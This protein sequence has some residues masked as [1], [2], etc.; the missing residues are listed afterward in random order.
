MAALAQ[1]LVAL[2]LQRQ[3][4][5]VDHV[6]EHAGEHAH[7][8]LVFLPVEARLVGEG[9]AHEGGQ[10]DR[11][12]QAGAVGRQRLL[13]AGVGRADVLAPPVVVHLVDPVD[14]DEARL[15][16][17][18]RRDHDHVPQVAGADVA[19]DLAGDQA[20]VAADVVLVRGPFA[21]DDLGLVLEVDLVLFLGVDREDHGP[22]GVVGHRFHEAVG[23]QQRQVEL[24]QAPVLALGPDEIL[25][26]RMGDV[27]GA[28]LRAAT[29][30][31][32]GHG[33][34][35][36]V[37][38]IHERH[39]PG[40]VRAG[41]GDE[42]AARTQGREFIADAAAR[43]EG[44]AGFVDLV[45][46]AVHRVLDGA[47]HGAVDGAG[48]RLV[49]L[50]AGVG[51]D[52][53]GGNGPAAQ[54]PD[55]A[56]VPVGALL[57]G[58]FG[59]GQGP[60]HAL[61]GAVDVGVQR[62]ALLGLEAVLLVPDIQR[63]RLHGYQ[64]SCSFLFRLDR[65]EAHRAHGSVALPVVSGTYGWTCF[66]YAPGRSGRP[67]RRSLLVALVVASGVERQ[68]WRSARRRKARRGGSELCVRSRKTA[69]AV[70]VMGY[71]RSALFP[72]KT[73]LLGPVS[74]LTAISSGK[75]KVASYARRIG[76]STAKRAWTDE[77]R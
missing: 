59:I 33:E 28:H 39:R 29:A 71:P 24:A 51:G 47:G 67:V 44:Q 64:G 4:V 7:H 27:E 12:E 70:A 14:Q 30:T 10:V 6:V 2:L 62:L 72:R 41:T 48:G 17:I 31:G 35:H 53:A 8:F 50:R 69:V 36:L 21:P 66:F 75:A 5:D 54:R 42:R 45:E 57:G 74:H 16:V 37:V 40:R 20:I 65:L 23:D 3:A 55:E 34:A 32:R 46:D 1:D 25:H 60:G 61:V 22:V 63:G 68:R 13:A 19:V 77:F 58:G 49:F 56:L 18:V 9:I 76:L 52:A 15:G 26:V 43:L 73:L 11:A 38:D